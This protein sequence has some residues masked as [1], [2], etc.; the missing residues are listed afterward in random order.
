MLRANIEAMIVSNSPELNAIGRDKVIRDSLHDTSLGLEPVDL[1]PDHR[2]RTEVLPIPV[3]SVGEPEV[4]S[5]VVLLNV[6]ETREVLAVEAVEEHARLVRS[7]V[8]KRELGSLVIKAFVAPH[9]LLTLTAV[10]RRS[11]AYEYV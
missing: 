10:G 1:R 8:H 6:I 7:R 4:S 5:V 9:D 3:T 2:L 11:N